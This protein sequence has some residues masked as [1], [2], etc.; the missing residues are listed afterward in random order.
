[1]P[2]DY[3]NVYQ[4][5]RHALG[6]PT[7]AFVTFFDQYARESANVL[8]IG[9]GQGR[10]ALFIARQGHHVVGVDLSATGV[11][12]MLEDAKTEKLSIEGIV[13]DL[14]DYTPSGEY[15]VVVIDR[16]LHMVDVEKRVRVL[17]QVCA[18]VREGGYVLIADE[19]P[20][21][22]RMKEVFVADRGDWA[23]IKEQRGF[24]FLQKTVRDE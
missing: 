20:N 12:Q 11:S 22:P 10:D 13:A 15:D 23:I 7:Q 9:C 4:Q 8:D 24:L 3:E 17:E 16:T 6:K 2:T 18:V 21:L 19:S 5:Q 14:H 1:M